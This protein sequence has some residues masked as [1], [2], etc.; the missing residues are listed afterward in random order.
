MSVHESLKKLIQSLENNYSAQTEVISNRYPIEEKFLSDIFSLLEKDID[1][2]MGRQGHINKNICMM[3]QSLLRPFLFLTKWL[4]VATR[5]PDKASCALI[6][7]YQLFLRADYIELYKKYKTFYQLAIQYDRSSEKHTDLLEAF[8][9]FSVFLPFTIKKSIKDNIVDAKNGKIRS[10]EFLYSINFSKKGCG[11]LLPEQIEKSVADSLRTLSKEPPPISNF[12]KMCARI[13]TEIIL[14]KDKIESILRIDSI[15]PP[16]KN[17]TYEKTKHAGGGYIALKDVLD[18]QKYSEL[19]V[20]GH[21]Y[22]NWLGEFPSVNNNARVALLVEANKVR[23]LTIQSTQ[24]QAGAIALQKYLLNCWKRRK[25]STMSKMWI[26]KFQK[27]VSDTK[28][29]KFKYN[30]SVDYSAATDNLNPS[31]TKE[32]IDTVITLNDSLTEKEKN[33]I[34]DILSSRDIETA[35]MLFANHPDKEEAH[36]IIEELRNQFN[37][38]KV[39]QSNGQLMGGPLSFPILCIANLAAFIGTFTSRPTERGYKIYKN[40]FSE[41]EEYKYIKNQLKT[42]KVRDQMDQLLINGDDAY[43]PMFS[44]KQVSLHMKTSGEFGLTVNEKSIISKINTTKQMNSVMFYK[45]KR[46]NYLNL[47]IYMNN[48]IKNVGSL[49]EDNFADCAEEFSWNSEIKNGFITK[50][51][52]KICPSVKLKYVWLPRC[53]GGLGFRDLAPN[54]VSRKLHYEI[55]NIANRKER[56][57]LNPNYSSILK[58]LGHLVEKG[59]K[60]SVVKLKADSETIFESEFCYLIAKKLISKALCN[61]ELIVDNIYNLQKNQ[62]YRIHHPDEYLNFSYLNSCR[63]RYSEYLDE[64]MSKVRN[65]F[66]FTPITLSSTSSSGPSIP[67]LIYNNMMELK[68]INEIPIIRNYV[69]P[70][71]QEDFYEYEQELYVIDLGI[72]LTFGEVRVPDV[73]TEK[74]ENFKDLA[75]IN[76]ILV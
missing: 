72:S 26:E 5:K 9:E 60:S 19:P 53:F 1:V 71:F 51:L 7:M 3:I 30:Y 14:G 10:M 55:L 28:F 43:S 35:T 70:T 62:V 13:A 25:F 46:V 33:L 50:W 76:H 20:N 57:I 41:E 48:N 6:K 47:A 17:A 65:V 11:V 23:F 52:N 31:I 32:I 21:E 54:T 69:R 56:V 44:L 16:T 12:N 58:D 8:K 67:E 27:L 73:H 75:F 63:V 36:S 24:L 15:Y 42:P 22:L 45:D 39:Y 66:R 37:D 29:S 61:K 64:V 18:C 40:Q 49:T 74:K 68:L 59:E 34:Y 4:S 2:H 38:N